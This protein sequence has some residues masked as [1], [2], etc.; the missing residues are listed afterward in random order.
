MED[1]SEEGKVMEKDDMYTDKEGMNTKEE[2]IELHPEIVRQRQDTYSSLTDLAGID[3]FYDRFQEIIEQVKKEKSEHFEKIEQKVF[4]DEVIE[5]YDA[6][7]HVVS[8]LFLGQEEFILR[9]D[10]QKN[11]ERMSI[12]DVSLILITILA[13]IALYVFFFND[14]KIRRKKI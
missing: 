7:I 6:D 14:K 10:Y 2:D 5:E 13:V 12:M 8:N 1:K 9:H 3:I 4:M 11:N